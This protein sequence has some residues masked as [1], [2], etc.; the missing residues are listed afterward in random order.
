MGRTIK[1][2]ATSHTKCRLLQAISRGSQTSLRISVLI[3][4]VS[5][6]LIVFWWG[7]TQTL[8]RKLPNLFIQINLSSQQCNLKISTKEK[9]L[10]YDSA[11]VR[12]YWA[13]DNLASKYGFIKDADYVGNLIC[14]WESHN[15]AVQYL[16]HIM[17]CTPLRRPHSQP[18]PLLCP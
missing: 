18:R 12:L 15:Y 5:A 3:M 1:F 6:N 9:F 10:G 14:T 2:I 4:R 8:I 13:G 11:L 16:V 17:T 7:K